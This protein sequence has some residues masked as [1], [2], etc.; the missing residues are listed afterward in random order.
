MRPV[1]LDTVGASA[2]TLCA[3]HCALMPLLGGLPLV[4]L[5]LFGH[6][7]CEQGL[8]FASSFL[9]GASLIRS[10]RRRHRQQRAVL[11]FLA[12]VAAMWAAHLV[13]EGPAE[14]A[15][16]ACGAAGLVAA[17]L[18]NWSLCRRCCA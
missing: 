13:L 12:G 7:A 14:I 16:G 3:I 5:E 15:A 18:I 6:P 8:L 4:G 2:S 1:I 17:H 9:A 10:Y 11:L